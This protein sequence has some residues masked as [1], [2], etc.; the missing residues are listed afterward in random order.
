MNTGRK[1]AY[2][3]QRTMTPLGAWRMLMHE[4][5]GGRRHEMGILARKMAHPETR[6]RSRLRRIVTD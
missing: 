5:G 6:M 3:E 1:D 2:N 4:R